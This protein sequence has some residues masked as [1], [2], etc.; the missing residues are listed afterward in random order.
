MYVWWFNNA[1]VT[2]PLRQASL[3]LRHVVA[4]DR[5]RCRDT[6][7][8]LRSSSSRFRVLDG[9]K[10]GQRLRFSVKPNEN[11]RHSKVTCKVCRVFEQSYVADANRSHMS[12]K[13]SHS[14]SVH[15]NTRSHLVTSYWISR[16]SFFPFLRGRRL[17]DALRH[18]HCPRMALKQYPPRWHVWHARRNNN[19]GEAT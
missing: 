12:P 8:R 1:C 4:F 5:R 17:G 11:V 13:S 14:C 3:K 10:V 6:V 9:Q 16:P 18:K 2:R 15:H 7:Y 19:S